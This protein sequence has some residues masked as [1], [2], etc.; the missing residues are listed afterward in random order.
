MAQLSLTSFFGTSYNQYIGKPDFTLVGVDGNAF[1]VIGYVKDSM[2]TVG[3]SRSEVSSFCET[4]MKSPNYDALLSQSILMIE[5][6]NTKLH[7]LIAEEKE[8]NKTAKREAL[9]EMLKK[10]SSDDNPVST[11]NSNETYT[12]TA[13]VKEDNTLDAQTAVVEEKKELTDEEM[14]A[15]IDKWFDEYVP[16]SGKAKSV[17]GEIL[18][19][20]SRIYYR[21]MNDGDFLGYGYGVE[22][23]GSEAVY[24][25]S[26]FAEFEEIIEALSDIQDNDDTYMNLLKE[27]KKAVVEF[28]TEKPDI[29]KLENENDSREDYDHSID[30]EDDYRLNFWEEDEDEEDYDDD[31]DDEDE[32]EDY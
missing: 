10:R 9:T 7:Q 26:E 12:V 24:L 14:D 6:C 27:L 15:L 1:S 19:A 16:A 29:F 25:Y 11:S 2:R 8:A 4:A 30:G 13:E 3:F 28:L 17:G 5:K 32:D 20:F 23:C 18:R 22:T 31:Y 21:Y